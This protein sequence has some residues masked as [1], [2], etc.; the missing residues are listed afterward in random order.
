MSSTRLH[1]VLSEFTA[2]RF[3]EEFWQ[4]KPVLI[5]GAFPD[6]EAPLDRDE[7]AGLTM[8][9]NVQSRLVLQEG[10]A[11][12]W[13]LRHGPFSEETLTTL[14]PQ[15]WSLL[16]QEVDRHV[17]AVADLFDLF[18]FLPDWR[19]DDVMVS[20][21]PTGAGVGAHIDS[22]DVFLLQGPGRRRWEIGESG[23]D[24]T[25]VE[26]LDVRVLANFKPTQVFELEMGDML[27]L[28]PGVPHNGVA[29]T[30]CFT[31]SFGFLAPS[32]ADLK[33]SW[34]YFLEQ[35]RGALRF[36]DPGREAG[37]V[38]LSDADLQRV[39]EL[40]GEP[41]AD[42]DTLAEF[43]GCFITREQRA[44]PLPLEVPELDWEE[45]MSESRLARRNEQ[46]RWC[47]RDGR[48]FVHGELFQAEAAGIDRVLSGREFEADP[49]CE[50][51]R[52]LFER[53]YLYFPGFEDDDSFED[54]DQ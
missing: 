48:L 8:D 7:L 12:P 43:F 4:K 49:D 22:Y 5:R 33:S 14:P 52:S 2:E 27:Y 23:G 54:E 46:V 34:S 44:Q 16:V 47:R 17:P 35:R 3:L 20:F 45:Q 6:F 40:M 50:L 1:P 18:D 51:Q 39:A 13:E 19:K 29:L 37:G 32:Q 41:S 9:P 26:G 21:A 10:G 31:Y 24:T 53:G 11:Y 15:G 36:S 30:D 38:E 25:L 28:P 42:R